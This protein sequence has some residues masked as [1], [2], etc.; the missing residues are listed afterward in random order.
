MA[1]L[2][3]PRNETIARAGHISLRDRRKHRIDGA[4]RRRMTS[5]AEHL[6]L[7]DIVS[8]KASELSWTDEVAQGSPLSA[9][10]GILIAAVIGIGMWTA[11]LA[12]L[13]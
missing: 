13:S 6:S 7:H 1:A 11:A 3:S 4:K 10:C 12:V 8:S 9:A 2:H 5:R